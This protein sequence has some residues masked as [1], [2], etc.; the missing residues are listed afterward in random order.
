MAAQFCPLKGSGRP[1]ESWHWLIGDARLM[2]KGRLI[3]P[4]RILPGKKQVARCPTLGCYWQSSQ[5]VKI[6]AFIFFSRDWLYLLSWEA[7]VTGCTALLARKVAFHSRVLWRFSHFA[8]SSRT[9]RPIFSD[10]H[11]PMQQ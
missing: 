8:T 9:L 5:S 11:L 4:R 1:A 10:S 7:W 6:A 2:R 3:P